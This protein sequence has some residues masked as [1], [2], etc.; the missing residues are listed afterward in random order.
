MERAD[1]NVDVV[2]PQISCSF[3]FCYSSVDVDVVMPQISCSFSYCYS[4]V[5]LMSL[6]DRKSVTAYILLSSS[7][8]V[9]PFDKECNKIE[10]IATTSLCQRR[11]CTI[12]VVFMLLAAASIGN[13]KP[14]IMIMMCLCVLVI[15]Q[16]LYL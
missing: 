14:C 7:P 1:R 4:S 11:P 3:S 5:P 6:Y 12:T 16:A 2:M 13:S 10:D 15:A 9:F 8:I